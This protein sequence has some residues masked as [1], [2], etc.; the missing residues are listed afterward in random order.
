MYGRSRDGVPE[1]YGEREFK[2]AAL[3]YVKNCIERDFPEDLAEVLT[4]LVDE[5][6]EKLKRDLSEGSAQDEDARAVEV[7]MPFIALAQAYGD[8]M[9]DDEVIKEYCSAVLDSAPQE[10]TE[11]LLAA[12]KGGMS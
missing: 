3:D 2:M 1:K 9:K 6:M 5:K 11:A 4:M 8:I 10:I 12:Q 7:M